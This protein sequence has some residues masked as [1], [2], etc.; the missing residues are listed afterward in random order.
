MMH[1]EELKNIPLREC[2]KSQTRQQP[3]QFLVQPN[4][5]LILPINLTVIQMMIQN[6]KT[7]QPIH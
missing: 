6:Q 1:W 2:L 7:L 4:R 3:K 5:H